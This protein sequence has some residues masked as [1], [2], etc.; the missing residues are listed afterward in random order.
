VV[1][2]NHCLMQ[3]RKAHKT[4]VVE[5]QPEFMQSEDFSHLDDIL[6]KEKEFQKL[7]KC[8]GTLN[9]EQ[10]S[11]I[12]LFYL[13]GKCYNE[14]VSQTGMDWNRVRSWYKMEEEI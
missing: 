5:F 7:H 4:V 13:D 12:N 14:I 2:K 6:E 11:I 9:E 1:A 10:K 3:L 8:I